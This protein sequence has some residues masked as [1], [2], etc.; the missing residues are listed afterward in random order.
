MRV[1]RLDRGRMRC[2]ELGQAAGRDRPRG[3]AELPAD[4]R[5]DAVDLPGKAVD[6]ADWSPPTVVLPITLGGST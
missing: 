5:D 2:D 4:R 3:D 1:D 6:D